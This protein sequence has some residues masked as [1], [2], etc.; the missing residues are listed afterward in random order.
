VKKAIIVVI[1]LCVIAIIAFSFLKP[2]YIKTHLPLPVTPRL[3]Y[4]WLR[5]K[6]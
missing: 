5:L 2:Y 4:I 6:I 3:Q 1:G